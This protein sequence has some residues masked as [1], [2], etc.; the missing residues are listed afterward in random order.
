MLRR[1][2]GA[3]TSAAALHSRPLRHSRPPICRPPSVTPLASPAQVTTDFRGHHTIPQE[4]PQV[5][6]VRAA[7]P[8]VLFRLLASFPA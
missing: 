2:A 8:R 1:A 3:T 5:L 4:F 6:K 7:G